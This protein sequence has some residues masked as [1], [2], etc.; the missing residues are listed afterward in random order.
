[1]ILRAQ[2]TAPWSRF[3]GRFGRVVSTHEHDSGHYV[4]L[5]LDDEERPLR[6]G[7]EAVDLRIPP[8]DRSSSR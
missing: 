6:F 5:W 7:L 8:P 4:M 1:V 3:R 2:V